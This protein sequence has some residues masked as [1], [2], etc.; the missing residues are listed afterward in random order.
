MCLFRF[1]TLGFKADCVLHEEAVSVAEGQGAAARSSL[2][3]LRFAATVQKP[4]L[5]AMQGKELLQAFF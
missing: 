5:G 2:P 3:V 1:F 4:A